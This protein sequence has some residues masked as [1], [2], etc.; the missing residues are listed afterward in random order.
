MVHTLLGTSQISRL[1]WYTLEYASHIHIMYFKTEITYI[2]QRALIRD[3]SKKNI[4]T[5]LQN[6]G[7]L[8]KLLNF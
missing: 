1:I 5:Y 8:F 6:H 4:A 3:K 2:S 7:V